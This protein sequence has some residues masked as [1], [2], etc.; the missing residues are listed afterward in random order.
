M[1]IPYVNL[2]ISMYVYKF[3]RLYIHGF[4]LE[5]MKLFCGNQFMRLTIRDIVRYEMKVLVGNSMR[6]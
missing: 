3:T 5:T 6:A 2:L 1:S 4:Y